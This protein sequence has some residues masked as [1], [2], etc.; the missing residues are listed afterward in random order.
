MGA[1]SEQLKGTRLGA[2]EIVQLVG[3]GGT[4][5]VFEA[6]HVS[7][8]K[9]V[10]V[11][12]L[13]EH[14]ASSAQMTT[15]FV[16][17]GRVAAR[18]QHPNIVNVIDVGTDHGLPYLVMELLSG[19]DLRALL[20]DVGTLSVE[21]ALDFLLPILSALAHAHAAGIIPRD[22]NPA[23]NFLARDGRDVDVP[24]LVDFGLSKV[25]AP[26]GEEAFGLT[27][28]G[29]VAGTVLYMAPEQTAGVRNSSAASDQYS[30]AAILYE[31]ITGEP[32]FTGDGVYALLE[33]IRS[34]PLRPPSAV[35]PK[36]VAEHGPE[37]ARALD[38]AIV[39]ALS[40]DPAARWPSIRAF[41]RELLPFASEAT[42]DHLT[43]DFVDRNDESEKLRTAARGSPRAFAARPTPNAETMLEVP[44]DPPGR[45]PA[46][47]AASK[48]SARLAT[49]RTAGTAGPNARARTRPGTSPFQ[50]KGLPYRG[51]MFHVARAVTLEAFL[52]ELDPD[53]RAFATQPFLASRRYD[54]FPFVPLFETLARM[55]GVAFETLVRAAT[56]AQ[57]RYDAR[58]A[59]RMILDANRPEDIVA[60]VERFNTQVFDFGKYS[61]AIPEKNRGVIVFAEIPA[62][63]EAWFA[64]M[65]VSYATESLRLAG[66]TGITV[67]SHVAED[68]GTH[69]GYPLRTYTTELRWEL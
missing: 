10:A 42:S 68:A 46:P 62:E 27:S 2:Y 6:T 26:D 13:H 59:Y 23:T 63:I 37:G 51:F 52:R 43:R 58:T 20:T 3:H 5:S 38:A 48:P 11:K 55:R 36:L 4:A 61:A 33:R 47:P 12:I 30:A 16:R 49:A 53:L 22:L 17:E 34:A 35:N 32:P 66:A 45:D 7:L 31:A 19:G 1:R 60:R 67:A 25:S 41:A 24:K 69:E 57:V 65:H 28:T 39:R 15:R 44:S 8:D 40:R 29:L 50:V 64:P 18:L 56:A 21:H 14:L 9:P 54:I